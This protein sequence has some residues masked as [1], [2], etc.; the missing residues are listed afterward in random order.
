MIAKELQNRAI[1][2]GSANEPNLL[3][4]DF[5]DSP[6]RENSIVVINLFTEKA[7]SR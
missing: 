6:F 3:L 2:L 1:P 5:S 7:Y 4:S